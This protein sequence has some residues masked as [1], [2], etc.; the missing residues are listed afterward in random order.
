MKPLHI[1][2]ATD[3]FKTATYTGFMG[4]DDPE[5]DGKVGDLIWINHNHYGDYVGTIKAIERIKMVSGT[6]S[7]GIAI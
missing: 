7:L 1:F 2:K 6:V 3:T 5:F 4:P